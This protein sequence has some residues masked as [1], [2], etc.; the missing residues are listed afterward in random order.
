M[1][2]LALGILL[3]SACRDPKPPAP[4]PP[5]P[6]P[7]DSKKTT[8]TGEGDLSAEEAGYHLDL[9][10]VHLRH[11]KYDE[12]MRLYFEVQ[13]RCK[14]S[15]TVGRAT[16]GV[17]LAHILRG[18]LKLAVGPLASAIQTAPKTT[19]SELRFMLSGVYVDLGNDAAAEEILDAMLR[20]PDAS[21]QVRTQVYNRLL[22]M[23]T[24]KNNV[25]GLAA[26][27]EKMTEQDP[28]N[29]EFLAVLGQLYSTH[30]KNPAKAL[31]V[32]EKLLTLD[33]E[34]AETLLLV[35]E[36]A[37][38]SGKHDRALEAME[39][40]LKGAEKDVA[41]QAKTLRQIG[42]LFL[43]QKAWEKAAAVLERAEKITAKASELH[44][45]RFGLYSALKEL[46]KLPAKVADLEKDAAANPKDESVLRALL[47]I[48][49]RFDGAVLKAEAVLARL[50]GMSPEEPAFLVAG[51]EVARQKGDHEGLI[52]HFE[53][54]L[55]VDARTAAS[56]MDPYLNA[57]KLV[58]KLE[59]ALPE[60]LKAAERDAAYRVPLLA[61]SG[62]LFLRA[63][64]QEDA[65][66]LWER[67]TRAARE[68]KKASDYLTAVSVFRRVGAA[69]DGWELLQEALRFGADA[70]TLASLLLEGA[71]LA[72][73][74]AKP[75]EA[76]KFCNE[77]LRRTE[78]PEEARRAAQRKLA[79]LR[80]KAG[81]K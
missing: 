55:A 66:K 29:R 76:E 80:Q 37:A 47:L 43:E 8:P 23:Y 28:K 53:K 50:L 59:R 3:L 33:P 51:V 56:V 35:M 64:R 61:Q 40:I 62:E 68:S 77:V 10:D 60:I 38:R 20:D 45:V 7:T 21:V 36:S 15:D 1:K 74:L 25:A 73:A 13:R 63:G 39:K 34:S 58:R 49:L 79:E 16:Y 11:K 67:M 41:A 81:K 75:D 18:E 24:K 72:E 12:A 71:E 44:E 57:L 9:A 52:V 65:V 14:D 17:A 46:G 78:L 32:H 31:A 30:L 42:A 27:L 48:H 2:R 6:T 69:K 22:E 4:V 70:P 54:L 5:A 19:R 26:K